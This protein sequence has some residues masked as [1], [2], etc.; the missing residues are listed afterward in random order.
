MNKLKLLLAFVFSVTVSLETVA[1]EPVDPATL[2]GV[3]GMTDVVVSDIPGY[4]AAMKA[5][6]QLFAALNTN[7]AGFCQAV[8]GG[9]PGESMVFNFSNSMETALASYDT[10]LNDPA[11][12]GFVANLEPYR[13]RVGSRQ[14]QIIRP[15]TGPALATW[16][17]R[18]LYVRAENPQAYI[19]AVG[20]LESTARANGFADLSLMVQREVGSGNTSDLLA[21]VAVSSSL[22]RLGAA[23]D[24]ITGEGWAQDAFAS[25]QA[26]RSRIMED[27]IYRC[28]QVYPA[29]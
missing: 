1:Q 23:L 8:S 16:A 25:V 24:A 5:N 17:T 29:I 2:G 26:A 21:V 27:K 7:L 12:A 22:T 11:F 13:E 9:V 15:Y 14:A 28:Q 6:S 4:V 19:D 20:A 10:Q 18:N 3:I